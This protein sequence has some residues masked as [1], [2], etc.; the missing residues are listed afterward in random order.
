MRWKRVSVFLF[1]LVL[2]TLLCGSMAFAVV[3]PTKEGYVND[4][5]DVLSEETEQYIIQTAKELEQKT[6]SQIVVVTIPSLDGAS[7]EEY[8]TEL[9]RSWGIGDKEKDN[10]L[11]LLVSIEDRKLRIEVG[12]GLEGDIPDGKAGRIR[13]Q[14]L[15]PYLKEDQFDEGIRSG[16]TALL[17]TVADVYDV[18]IDG[19]SEET[20]KEIRE[21]VEEDPEF[22][23]FGSIISSFFTAIFFCWP[24]ALILRPGKGK[25][26]KIIYSIIILPDLCT[27]LISGENLVCTLIIIFVGFL[28][29]LTMDVDWFS[30]GS[31]GGGDSWGDGGSFSGGDSW[32]GGGGSSGGGGASGDF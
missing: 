30:G 15:I 24:L 20:S 1:S 31:F 29:G 22:T 19:V 16:Y 11:L 17:S 9:F 28:P 27:S 12:Y 10:G 26:R 13:D 8:A 7:I 18:T 4:Y 3:S 21:N 5:G 25:I 6:S 2:I 14:Y 32:S 23:F